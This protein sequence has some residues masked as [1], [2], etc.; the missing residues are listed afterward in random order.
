M[1]NH[2][3][4]T[5]TQ[6]TESCLYL[7]LQAQMVV[8]VDPKLTIWRFPMIHFVSGPGILLIVALYLLNLHH[9]LEPWTINSTNT[10]VTTTLR[11]TGMGLK[12]AHVQ[13]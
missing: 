3:V 10:A 13:M 6:Y 5:S 4:E 12:H 2:H 9:N 11:S 8:Y 7:L 1:T